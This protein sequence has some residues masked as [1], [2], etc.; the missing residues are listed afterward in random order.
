M[1]RP[2]RCRRSSS[3]MRTYH[4]QIAAPL[5]HQ[6]HRLRRH[7]LPA[8]PRVVT[9]SA[10]FLLVTSLFGA[11]HS[12]WA[13]ARAAGRARCSASR[14][15][16]RCSRSP[17]R[18]RA[19]PTTS[20]FLQRFVVIPMSLFAGVY[21]PVSSLPIGCSRWSTISPLW[22]GVELCRAATH[23]DHG[24]LLGTARPRRVS[25]AVGGRRPV[26]GAAAIPSSALGLGRPIM[27]VTAFS[28]GVYGR[29]D[30]AMRRSGAVTGR[31]VTALRSAYWLLLALRLLRAGA[32]S[33]V[34]RRRPGQARSAGSRSAAARP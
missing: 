23:A 26:A 2:G 10:V 17:P 22:H 6:R 18:S 9:T 21:F 13:L 12:W 33:A 25:R 14:S 31:N 1:S 5:A 16:R 8:V 4:A 29:I 11:V 20:P 7:D 27:V 30:A 24:T 32:L 3:W 15:P 19:A 28:P 34:D